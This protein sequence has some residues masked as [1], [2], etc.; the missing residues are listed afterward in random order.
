M[1][2]NKFLKVAVA[3]AKADPDGAK[4]V[5]AIAN[6]WL[7]QQSESRIPATQQSFVAAAEQYQ[8]LGK[9]PALSEEA[10]NGML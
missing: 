3:N 1:N 2:F 7:A 6:H 4:A 8:A 10:N 5:L 9:Y